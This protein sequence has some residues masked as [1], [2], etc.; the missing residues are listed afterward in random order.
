MVRIIRFYVFY[1]K[2]NHGLHK[3]NRHVFNKCVCIII[4]KYLSVYFF[5]TTYLF[6]LLFS[7]CCSLISLTYQSG[8][9]I[10]MYDYEI[11]TPCT[12]E[13]L[14]PRWGLI[15]SLLMRSVN[16]SN[17]IWWSDPQSMVAILEAKMGGLA[18][19]KSY[20]CKNICNEM[21]WSDPQLPYYK[22]K[23]VDYIYP[24]GYDD[25]IH[26]CHSSPNGWIGWSNPWLPK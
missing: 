3:T 24:M 6:S 17:E 11:M 10:I 15:I 25:L 20:Q 2:Y 4:W 22:P 1:D 7:A 18:S 26:G 8:L 14:T 16:I 13:S 23:W 19:L 12:S 5:L 9:G 21:W